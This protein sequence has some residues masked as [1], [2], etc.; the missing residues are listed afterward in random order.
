MIS[1]RIK[2]SHHACPSSIVSVTKAH[3]L[4]SLSFLIDTTDSYVFVFILYHHDW[5]FIFNLLDI[6]IRCIM[7][8]YNNRKYR[9][10]VK[11][12]WIFARDWRFDSLKRMKNWNQVFACDPLKNC[13]V[14]PSSNSKTNMTKHSFP[15]TCTTISRFINKA[16]RENVVES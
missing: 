3:S 8:F 12:D 2:L 1:N 4:S 15:T 13:T 5:P 14:K 10:Y 7:S 9:A 11:H 6:Q 16:S